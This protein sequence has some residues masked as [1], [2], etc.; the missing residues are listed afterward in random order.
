MIRLTRET[1]KTEVPLSVAFE[2]VATRGLLVVDSVDIL[3]RACWSS[4][5]GM[6]ESRERKLD[7]SS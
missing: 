1:G 6:V 3:T 2:L 5:S 4:K 7:D